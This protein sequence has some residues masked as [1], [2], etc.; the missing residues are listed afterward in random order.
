MGLK[1]FEEQEFIDFLNTMNER[2][3]RL[4]NMHE[5]TFDEVIS[6]FQEY[7]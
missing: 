7:F 3:D 1:L 6:K 2:K 4:F 5:K